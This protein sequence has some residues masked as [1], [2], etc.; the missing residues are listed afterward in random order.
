MKVALLGIL[1]VLAASLALNA[2]EEVTVTTI[3]VW[4]AVEGSKGTLTQ[5]D[6]EVFEDGKKMTPTCF[7]EAPLPT[8][9]E[10]A[11]Y[12]AAE[13]EAQ[14][15][16]QSQEAAPVPGRSLKRIVLMI[17]EIN[18]SQ[19][20]LLFIKR[21]IYEFLK[22]MEGRTEIMLTTVP[23]YEERTP[24]TS[25]FYELRTKLDQIRGSMDRDLRV[26]NRRRAIRDIIESGRPDAA[27][28]AYELAMEGALEE[29][30]NI[31]L[32]FDAL[33]SF[34]KSLNANQQNEHTVVIFIS[35]GLNSHP[36]Q[37]YMD[38]VDSHL[39]G[40]TAEREFRRQHQ[41]FSRTIEAA[42]GSLNRDNVTAYTINA[43][44][45]VDPVDN[46]T[47][48]NQ[49]FMASARQNVEYRGDYQELMDQVAND[50]GG[51]SFHNSLNFKRGFDA[52]LSDLDHQYLICY[53]APDHKKEGF[54]KIEVSTKVK[55][56]KIRHRKGYID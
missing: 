42:L 16:S 1:L 5:A 11:A 4:V 48:N 40:D 18:T 27:E 2:Q 43:R 52:I 35:G 28:K 45:Q 54:H 31:Q 50:T 10:A 47:E 19:A 39:G 21:K 26:A 32:V 14:T 20:E 34:H 51:V 37:Q 23:P 17:D 29:I 22:Q 9:Q 56:I 38:M 25:D 53:V 6:F 3:R 13:E 36:G 49:G 41:N 15:Q 44:G 24:F 55:G 33:K 8:A 30:Q 46:I 7:E 12:E